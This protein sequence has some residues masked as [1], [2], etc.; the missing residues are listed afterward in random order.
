MGGMG[1]LSRH[2]WQLG[3]TAQAQPGVNSG[4][5]LGAHVPGA[6]LLPLGLFPASTVATGQEGHTG[7]QAQNWGGEGGLPSC[8]VFK[9]K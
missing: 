1:L 4:H 5:S 6:Y 8:T 7:T 2:C 9:T 3:I